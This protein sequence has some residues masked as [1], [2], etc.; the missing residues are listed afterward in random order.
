MATTFN[1]SADLNK[2]L[3]SFI[4]NKYGFK[5]VKVSIVYS[6]EY[7]PNESNYIFR[8]N[9]DGITITKDIL[10]KTILLPEAVAQI[11]ENLKETHPELFI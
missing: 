6:N 2:R 11:M 7:D 8:A 3:E 1:P 5:K 10:D 9:L 4:K